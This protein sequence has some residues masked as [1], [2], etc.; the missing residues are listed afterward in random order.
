MCGIVGITCQDG[1]LTAMLMKEFLLQSQIR[2][3]H[4]TGISYIEKNK[5]KTIKEPVSANKFIKREFPHSTMMIGH[6]R[7]STSDIE[8]NQ[9]ISNSELSIVHNGI[10]TQESF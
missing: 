10:I 4:A 7:Y 3:K 5:I 8:Y 2:G 6:T 1:E 9:P